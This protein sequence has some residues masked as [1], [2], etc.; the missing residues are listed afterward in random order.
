VT[1]RYRIA[2]LILIALFKPALA[3]VP[4]GWRE[5]GD[6]SLEVIEGS[7]LDFSALVTAG[8]AGAKGGVQANT[9]GHLRFAGD[10]HAQRFLCASQPYG[11]EAG[12]PDHET[13]NRY[14]RQLKM[15]GYNLARF[16]FVDN[17]LMNGMVKDFG[18]NPVQ[19][20]R[21]H[22]FLSA[23]KREGI[24]WVLDGLTSWNAAYGD[25]GR[26]RWVQRRNVKL[27]VYFDPDQ[28]AH[29]K[30]LVKRLLGTVNPYTGMR[31]LDDPALAG[32]IL[33]NEGGLNALINQAHSPEMDGLFAKYLAARY[34]SVG[35]A[36]RHWGSLEALSSQV[37]L[38]RGVWMKSGK[39]VDT[40]RFYYDQQLKTVTWMTAYI[41]GLGYKGLVTA[42]DNWPTL[43]DQATRANLSWVDM[44]TYHDNPS[45][46]ASPGSRIKQTSSL[47]DALGYVRNAATARYWGKP[48]TVSEFDQPFWNRWRFES[49]LA[50]GAYAGF[51]GWDLLCRHA[52]GP[53]ELAYGMDDSS[54]RQ[55]IYPYGIGMDPIA[56]AGETLAAIL[57]LRGDVQPAK[58][59]IGLRLTPEYVFDQQGGIG[60]LPDDLTR[61]GLITGIGLVW[62]DAKLMQPLDAVIDP[63]S[64]SPT[65][66]NKVM[67]KVGLGAESQLSAV[68]ANLRKQGILAGNLSDGKNYF[69]SDTKEISLDA[70]AR[71]M[72]VIT[73][74]TE[75]TAFAEV[76]GKLDAL[77]V[78]KAS[79]PALVSAS[80][81]DGAA[82]E[83]SRRILLILASDARNSGMQFADKNDEELVRLGGM[84]ILLRNIRVELALRHGNPAGLSLYALKLNGARGQKIP[85]TVLDGASAT[86]ILD[87]GALAAGPT[88]YFELVEE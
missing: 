10:A 35:A 69:E 72:K 4:D 76:P 66:V 8:P 71:V 82:L 49:G 60:Q 3:Q 20:D 27:G 85:I 33:V 75:A 81:L 53:I 36:K 30:E 84:P 18:F 70:D 42:F 78:Q 37:T 6:H 43:Q 61:L 31:I 59:H 57:Y 45:A 39:M 14:A 9:N 12:F 26:N 88:T 58:K 29:W 25:V 73:P 51:Q 41:R 65:L 86:F 15:H 80:S 63:V 54:R 11:V 13:A 17:V 46:Y 19:L 23:L 50:M 1:V 44:H 40:Q 38:P 47:E 83:K 28:Q 64:V 24:Y 74:R 22:Y 2:L 77:S 68:L 62:Q 7:A 79:A 32:V 52:S 21:F 34:G 67:Q 5:I 16:T 55:A 87:T 56:R 48:F